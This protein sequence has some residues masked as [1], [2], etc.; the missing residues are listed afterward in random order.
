MTHRRTFIKQISAM[1]GIAGLSAVIDTDEALADAIEEIGKPGYGSARNFKDRYMLDPRVTYFNHGSMGTIPRVVH[2][3]HIAYLKLL[4][5]NPWFYMWSGAW[6]EPRELVRAKMATVLACSASE[7]ALTHNTTEGFSLLASGLPLGPGDEVLFSTV[8]HP[9]ASVCW[10]HHG[11]T[12][13]YSVKEFEIPLDRIPEITTDEILQLYDDQITSSTRVLAFPHVDNTVGLRHPMAELARFAKSR[14]VEYVAVD[15]AQTLGMLELGVGNSEVDFYC[16]S[17]HKWLQAPKGLGVM[18][19]REEVQQD[20]R[21]MWVTWGQ[22]RW[23][24]SVRV[25]EDYGTR[26]LAEVLTLGDAIDFQTAI[27]QETKTA[28]YAALR[29]RFIDEVEA[30]QF[31]SWS[32]P[33][34]SEM[35]AS[36]Y[37]FEVA[38]MKSDLFA[39]RMFEELGFVMRPFATDQLNTVRIS[40]NV[41]NT[42]EDISRFMEAAGELL[43]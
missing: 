9:G 22:K 1:A 37:A 36:L 15:G 10:E 13:G 27:G 34:N 41:A 14:G 11:A 24:G 18:Y 19:I 2:D 39:H 38:G 7:V 31:F 8:N 29:N 25:F 23:K 4:E 20:L 42:Q 26:N 43:G 40:P 28:H 30:S 21:A 17:P 6:E 16:G 5:T 3:A 12:R 33:R 32:S 35:A